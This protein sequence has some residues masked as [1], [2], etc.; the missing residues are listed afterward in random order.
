MI[1]RGAVSQARRVNACFYAS[2]LCIPRDEISLV[3]NFGKHL[4]ARLD[5]Q[6]QSLHCEPQHQ[7]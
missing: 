7:Q 5:A 3:D 4:I 2:M 6:E 1:V